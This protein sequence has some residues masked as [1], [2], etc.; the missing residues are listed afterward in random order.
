M[1]FN[2]ARANFYE[3][4]G[5][6]KKMVLSTS[7]HDEVTSRM[8]SVV[9][10]GQ[11]IY[12]QTDRAFRKYEQLKKNPRVS[13]CADNLQIEGYCEE[14]GTPLDNTEFCEAYKKYFPG[15]YARYS[16]LKN[17]RLFAVTPTFVEKWLYIDGVPYI[18]TLDIADQR[19]GLKR[20]AGV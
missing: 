5:G 8:M 18:E 13:L 9:V 16:A 6:S 19:Y 7:F 20:Y 2:E 10:I 15:S 12:F 11:K 3:T 1:N 14:A 4:L 17:E